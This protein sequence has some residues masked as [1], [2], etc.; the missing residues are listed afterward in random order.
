MSL[1]ELLVTAAGLAAIVWVNW[2]FFHPG[3]SAVAASGTDSTQHA[4]IEV[5]NGYS[6]AI[7][8]VRAGRRSA[9]SFIGST[10]PAAPRK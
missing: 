10:V 4:R 1:G 3:A 5:D 9:S 6:P 8:R 7:V 2:Y